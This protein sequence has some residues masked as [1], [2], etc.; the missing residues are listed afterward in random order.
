MK[1]GSDVS[2]IA[3]AT[4]LKG[5]KKRGSLKKETHHTLLPSRFCYLKIGCIII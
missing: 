4:P 3:F 1:R 2:N 5:R